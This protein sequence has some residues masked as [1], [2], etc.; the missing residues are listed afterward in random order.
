MH[1]RLET[2]PDEKYLF[3]MEKISAEVG[4]PTQNT[5]TPTKAIENYIGKVSKMLRDFVGVLVFWAGRSTSAPIFS[6]MTKYFTS[7]VVFNRKYIPQ[8]C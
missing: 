2:T 5:S 1:F 6:M 4:R 3:I 7:G 8:L